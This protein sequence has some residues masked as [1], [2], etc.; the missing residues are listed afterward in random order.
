MCS[1]LVSRESCRRILNVDSTSRQGLHTNTSQIVTAKQSD[2][3]L[4][5]IPKFEP[6]LF[7]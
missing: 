4:R 6:V 1:R 7:V 3:T 5:V 2:K